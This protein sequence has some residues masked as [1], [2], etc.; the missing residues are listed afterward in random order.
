MK[1]CWKLPGQA[2]VRIVFVL[3]CLYEQ[4]IRNFWKIV[5]L[6]CFYY[7]HRKNKSTFSIAKNFPVRRW[8]LMLCCVVRE[9][10]SC[11]DSTMQR[12]NCEPTKWLFND[13]YLT[14]ILH[15]TGYHYCLN[16]QIIRNSFYLFHT[17]LACTLPRERQHACVISTNLQT[18]FT[19][20]YWTKDL[21]LASYLFMFILQLLHRIHQTTLS[22]IVNT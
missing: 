19:N 17:S 13:C 7:V 22:W 5:R 4:Y 1:S 14:V 16:A 21:L 10:C 8:S 2:D 3:N 18:L 20:Y 9:I 12:M 6:Y 15:N 11:L